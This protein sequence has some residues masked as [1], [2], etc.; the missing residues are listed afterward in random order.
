MI[1]ENYMIAYFHKNVF[2]GT[3]ENQTVTGNFYER[4]LRALGHK[5]QDVEVYKYPYSSSGKES[6]TFD[7]EKR[8][9]V[10]DIQDREVELEIDGEIQ[11]ITKQVTLVVETIEGEKV[12][13]L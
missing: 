9:Q 12:F 6:F 10:L 13:P 3:W 5:P 4:T 2:V 11:T 1:K 7:T 8:I